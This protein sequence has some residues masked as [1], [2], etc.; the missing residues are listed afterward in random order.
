MKIFS[1]S[2][3]ELYRIL[4]LVIFLVTLLSM[5]ACSIGDWEGYY[6]NSDYVVATP[7]E[8]R[9]GKIQT[10]YGKGSADTTYI[11]ANDPA[12]PKTNTCHDDNSEFVIK[13]YPDPKVPDNAGFTRTLAKDECYLISEIHAAL[14][15]PWR[16]QQCVFA[17]N[18]H[19]YTLT[20]INGVYNNKTGE[21]TPL[22]HSDGG[23]PNAGVINAESS[24]AISL[25][26][27]CVKGRTTYKYYI[28]SELQ[29]N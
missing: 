6:N 16:N 22:Y 21:F 1:W 3:Q 18:L 25:S 14:V 20:I 13:I 5:L 12:N 8:G 15:N 2:N 27:Y 10:Y 4:S 26:Y 28:L 24:T 9:F 17:D 23:C 11:I 19:D 7:N 29:D